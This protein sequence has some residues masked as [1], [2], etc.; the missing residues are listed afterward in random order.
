M[1]VI[2]LLLS[3]IL[4]SFERITY[5][6]VSRYPD[7]WYQTCQR[8]PLASFGN[9]VDALHA[10][11]YG[12]KVIQGGVFVYWWMRFGD[13]WMPLPTA[14]G[15]ALTAGLL[16][17]GA[18]VFLNAA[19]FFRLRRTGV[20]YGAEIG[21]DVP[22]IKGFPFSVMRHPQYLGAL[23]CI[24]GLFLV[25]RFPNDDWF[26]LPLME[27]AFYAWGAYHEP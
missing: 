3:A 21:Y 6:L 20:F 7:R 13:T 15:F 24:W 17:I 19:V 4:L 1:L 8:P 2:I 10:L 23:S 14:G 25:M 11:F 27:T 16:L 22:W 26:Y 5:F 12:F 9:P 18:G